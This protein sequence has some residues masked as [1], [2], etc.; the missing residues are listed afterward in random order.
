[1]TEDTPRGPRALTDADLI[2]EHLEALKLSQREAGRQLGIDNRTMRYYCAGQLPVPPAVMLALQQLRAAPAQN[3]APPVVHPALQETLKAADCDPRPIDEY[4]FASRLHTALT[5]VGGELEPAEKRGAFAVIGGLRFMT[6]HLHGTPVWDMHWQ[7]LSS[8]TD[9]QDR[10]YNDPDTAH[11]DDEIITEWSRLA[12]AVQ[13]P[14]LRARYADLAWEVAKFRTSAAPEAG[15]T[16]A[17]IRPNPANARLAIDA[18]LDAVDGKL[19]RDV[20][21]AGAYIGR[22]VEL[23]ATI[24]DPQRMQRAK[25]TLFAYRATAEATDPTYPFWVFDNIA[26]EQRD[27]LDLSAEEKT[28]AIAALERALALRTDQTD[29][30]HFDP[31]SA[32]DTADRLGRWRRQLGEDTEARRAADTAGRAMEAAAEK[33]SALT[34]IALLEG[35]VAR[36]RNAGDA[37]SAARVEQTIRRRAP[38]AR[39]E[40]RRFET[41]YEVPKDELDNWADQ[42][43]GA[44]FEQG[45]ARVVGANLIRKG[46]TEAQ[47]LELAKTA[48]LSARLNI[49]IMRDDGFAS[50]IIGSVEDDLEGRT[51]HQ[52][53]NDF[54]YS[55]PFLNVALTHFRAK[56]AVDL[57]RLM[58]WLG[59]SPFFSE[60]RLALVSDGLSAWLAEDWVKAIH[61]LVPQIEAAL[62]DLLSELGGSVMKPGRHGFQSIPLGEVLSAPRFVAQVPEDVRF[63]LRVL[64]TDPRGINLRNEALHGLAAH[65]L[66]GRGIA[67]WVVHAL[68]LVGLVRVNRRA[69]PPAPG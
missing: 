12:S 55:A 29:P 26:W 31:H 28:T 14:V 4:D 39:G 17:P 48:V 41:R 15:Q 11:V 50:A 57:E 42:V 53:A 44:T 34:A 21:V 27:A 33:A 69:T 19:A 3:A 61:V 2:R 56:H 5:A 23:S 67:N 46:K 58:S 63:H 36:Y 9:S 22:A 37:D 7:P 1:M 38:E 62:R 64:L 66:F 18:Y 6:R 68:I 35:Q 65:Q 40:F 43:A 54:G 60:S 13:H 8:F 59:Q 24:R 20:F 30:K 32:Q 52:A 25:D 16:M 10:V 51:V 49:S 47:V 45:L